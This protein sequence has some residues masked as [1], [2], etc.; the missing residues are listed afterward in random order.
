M[1]NSGVR[2][3]SASWRS[4]FATARQTV[5]TERMNLTVVCINGCSYVA[6]FPYITLASYHCRY[7]LIIYRYIFIIDAVFILVFSMPAFKK[8]L[9]KRKYIFDYYNQC[10]LTGL[11]MCSGGL[12]L[13]YRFCYCVVDCWLYTRYA[14]E[15]HVIV[16]Y[17]AKVIMF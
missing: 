14:L 16:P 15:T 8:I 7:N 11:K 2:M 17:S 10:R 12:I 3:E 4:G 9:C 13:C 6:S 1:M 5:S